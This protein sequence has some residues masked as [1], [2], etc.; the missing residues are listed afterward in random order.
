MTGIYTI[1]LIL[2]DSRYVRNEE[3]GL[4]DSLENIRFCVSSLLDVV[5][6]QRRKAVEL[7]R[8]VCRRVGA[9]R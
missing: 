2:E 6:L 5:I 9:G 7:H 8:A 3:G 1:L 4:K